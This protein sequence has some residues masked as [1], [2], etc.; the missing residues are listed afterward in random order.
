MDLLRQFM[1]INKKPLLVKIVFHKGW[2]IFCEK[3]FLCNHCDG[4]EMIFTPKA[5]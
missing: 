1:S 4:T 5:W 2:P 3:A